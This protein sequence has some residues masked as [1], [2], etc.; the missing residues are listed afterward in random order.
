[1]S[2]VS[3]PSI[4]STA[5]TLLSEPEFGACVRTRHPPDKV[6]TYVLAYIPRIVAWLG[7]KSVEVRHGH[8]AAVSPMVLDGV[9]RAARGGFETRL[10]VILKITTR[11]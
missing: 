9:R 11:G 4:G 2:S 8:D 5:Q 7:V 6:V 1:M 3:G 10:A